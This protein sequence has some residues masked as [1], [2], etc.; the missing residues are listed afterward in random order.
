MSFN[1]F[2][3]SNVFPE[4]LARHFAFWLLYSLIFYIQSISLEYNVQELF[5]WSTYFNAL[6]SFLCFVPVCFFAVYFS[7]YVLMPSFLPQKRYDFFALAFIGLFAFVY[8]LDYLS[9]QIFLHNVVQPYWKS[10]YQD[11][12]L[13]FV[14]A[15]HA[16]ILSVFGIGIKLT[17]SWYQQ[18]EENCALGK[19]KN[20]TELQL[21]KSKIHPGFLFHSLHSIQSNIFR[22]SPQAPDMILNL[23][24]QLSYILYESDDELVALD[25][26]L[27]ILDKFIALENLKAYP[28]DN[29]SITIDGDA[30]GYWIPPLVVLPLVQNVFEF[31]HYKNI[32]HEAISI[33]IHVEDNVLNLGIS[34]QIDRRQILEFVDW[35]EVLSAVRNRLEATM[36]GDYLL[37]AIRNGQLE[38][39]ILE[40]HL[41]NYVHTKGGNIVKENY[42]LLS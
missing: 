36:P 32:R 35:P 9:T 18:K 21:L 12:S 38:R 4:R 15:Q 29:I 31:V 19:L 40:I 20:R 6:L 23:S 8:V 26:E 25:K 5:H 3:F 7:I 37:E 30:E 10:K 13:A 2:V 14:N 39:I 1:R 41:P 16:I 11:L 33:T 22:R 42:T 24:D 27:S 34:V 17:K 28:A